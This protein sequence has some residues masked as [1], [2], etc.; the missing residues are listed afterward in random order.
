[1]APRG[2][3]VSCRRPADLVAAFRPSRRGRRRRRCP[4]AGG[5]RVR[6]GQRDGL[7]LG[8]GRGRSTVKAGRASRSAARR[9]RPTGFACGR[10]RD[11][12]AASHRAGTVRGGAPLVLTVSADSHMYDPRSRSRT[13][14]GDAAPR[15]RRRQP[16][17]PTS[18]L[19]DG[20]RRR[21]AAGRASVDALVA[22][23]RSLYATLA[24]DV[25]I[26][27]LLGPPRASADDWYSGEAGAAD[28][29]DSGGGDDD[30]GAARASVPRRVGERGARALLARAARRR[31]RRL[32]GQTARTRS[33]RAAATPRRRQPPTYAAF[34]WG[35]ALVVTLDLWFHRAEKPR[36]A[37]GRGR[38]LAVHARRRAVQ[39]TAAHARGDARVK[40]VFC[41]NSP[42]ARR[43]RDERPPLAARRA[44]RRGCTSGAARPTTTRTRRSRRCGGL[45]LPCTSCSSST[46]SPRSC[47][48]DTSSPPRSAT[49][50]S[51][52]ARLPDVAASSSRWTP[53]GPAGVVAV[54]GRDARRRAPRASPSTRSPRASTWSASRPATCTRARA[55]KFKIAGHLT[56]TRA[57]PRRA[58]TRD[59]ARARAP[60]RLA[61]RAARR[62]RATRAPAFSLPRAHAPASGRARRPARAPRERE[63]RVRHE[64]KQQQ[65]AARGRRGRAR[66]RARAQRPP[67]ARAAAG[68]GGGGRRRARRRR[69]GRGERAPDRR[70]EQRR[71]RRGGEQPARVVGV[72][73]VGE[74][75]AASRRPPCEHVHDD[76]RA[77]AHRASAVRQTCTCE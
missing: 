15:R 38:E 22:G 70:R 43:G 57:Q 2:G 75:R 27:P 65:H 19:V 73:R 24:A 32:A 56:P 53:S 16:A 14:C 69:R 6:A 29:A 12:R 41:H 64:P 47:S 77:R 74:R 49:A 63:A 25:P 36:R 10:E 58:T 45:G 51:T 48:H 9:R 11:A 31:R 20:R 26:V 66:G 76:A 61:H 5:G 1:M 68:D 23:Y 59:A 4:T 34:E 40:L 35:D 13:C 37:R 54:R 18:L 46:A 28:G 7:A 42:A 30:G 71:A 55:M 52:R 44:R 17:P 33:P 72:G 8:A 50:C 62:Q 3:G 60:P 39:L 67:A 21:G